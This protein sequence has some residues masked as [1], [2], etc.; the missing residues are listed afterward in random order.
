LTKNTFGQPK[1]IWLA[2]IFWT[3][4]FIKDFDVFDQPNYF[5]L[6]KKNLVEQMA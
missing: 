5:W 4:I 2:K 6:A 1:K 3:F